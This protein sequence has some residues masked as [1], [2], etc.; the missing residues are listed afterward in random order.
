MVVAFIESNL[1]LRLEI[2]D[3][4][5]SAGLSRSRVRHVF[6]TGIGMSPMRYVRLRRIQKAKVLLEETLLSVK[7]VTSKVGFSDQSHF[8]RDFSKHYGL[9]PG[10]YRS[11]HFTGSKNGSRLG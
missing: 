1:Q 5:R 10:K 6:T 2:S 4:A 9:T 3:I 11:E 8:V 7:E